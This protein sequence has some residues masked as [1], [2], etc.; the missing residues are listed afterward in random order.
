VRPAQV[1]R[2]TALLGAAPDGLLT[3]VPAP[4]AGHNV[5]REAPGVYLAAL[6]A[7]VALAD[8]GIDAGGRP[9]GD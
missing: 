5:R 8:A 7:A 9:A 3:H 2:A 6:D 4:G 1:E